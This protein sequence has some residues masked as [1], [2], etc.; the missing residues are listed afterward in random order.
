MCVSLTAKDWHKWRETYYAKKPVTQLL[1]K[2]FIL[3]HGKDS[4]KHAALL[5]ASD[6]VAEQYIEERFV[7]F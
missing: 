4:T 2:T 7:Q 3:E 1:G 5:E 6:R